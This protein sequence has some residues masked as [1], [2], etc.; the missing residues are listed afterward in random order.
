MFTLKEQACLTSCGI[1]Y[2]N[3]SLSQTEDPKACDKG[4]LVFQ[5]ANMATEVCL[6][7]LPV[8]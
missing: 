3:L 1:P 8:L 5:V 6:R 7:G 4:V 2:P